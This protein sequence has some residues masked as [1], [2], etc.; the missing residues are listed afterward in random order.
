M[1]VFRDRLY[2]QFNFLVDL[3]D[4]NAEAVQAAFRK[5]AVTTL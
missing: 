2:T 5:S 3:G 4:G 1:A